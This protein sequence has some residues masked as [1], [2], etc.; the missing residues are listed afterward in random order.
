MPKTRLISPGS[1]PNHKL[2]KN[3]QLQGNYISNDGGDEG[4]AIDNNGNVNLRP[5][6]QDVFDFEFDKMK[7]KFYGDEDD[8]LELG[9]GSG[10]VSTI[11]TYADPDNN[12]AQLNIEADGNLILKGSGSQG[13]QVSAA[14]KTES[15]LTDAS[16]SITEILNLSSGAGGSDIHYGLK[17]RQTQTNLAGWDS[18]YLMHLSVDGS[19]TKVVSVDKDAKLTCP[20][21]NVANT[22]EDG[23]AALIDYDYSNAS[24]AVKQG[25]RVD[26]DRTGSVSSG[27]DTTYGQYTTVNATGA[28]GGTIQSF[29]HRIAVTGDTGGT[30]KAIGLAVLAQSADENYAIITEGGNVGIGVDDPDELLEVA[31]DTKISGS[32]KLYLYDSGGEYISGDGTDLTITSGR[33]VELA[34]SNVLTHGSIQMKEISSTP[35]ATGVD[36][37]GFLWIKNTDPTEL[38]F[39]NDDGDDIQITTS[40]LL[41]PSSAV[42]ADDITVGNAQ[43]NIATSSGDIVFKSNGNSGTDEWL[44]FNTDDTNDDGNIP[45]SEILGVNNQRLRIRGQG[46]EQDLQIFSGKNIQLVPNGATGNTSVAIW[47]DR[48]PTTG[49]KTLS[50]AWEANQSAPQGITQLASQ[51]APAAQYR[52]STSGVGVVVYY[53]TDGSGNPTFR[54]YPESGGKNYKGKITI[55]GA[56]WNHTSGS[57]ADQAIITHTSVSGL[58]VYQSIRGT[59]I[60]TGAYIGE[61]TDSTHFVI[62]VDGAVAATTATLSSQTIYARERVVFQDGGDQSTYAVLE[63]ERVGNGRIEFGNKGTNTTGSPGIMGYIDVGN[64]NA[65]SNMHLV[66]E[67]RLKL[68]SE[69]TTNNVV[70]LDSNTVFLSGSAHTAI[71][72]QDYTSVHGGDRF[73]VGNSACNKVRMRLDG[74]DNTRVF[75]ITATDIDNADAFD[76]DA[77]NWNNAGGFKTSVTKTSGDTLMESSGEIKFIPALTGTVE[78]E[79]TFTGTTNGTHSLVFIDYDATG[80]T[81]DGQTINNIALNL[82]LNSNSQTAHANG[83]VNNTGIDIDMVGGTSGTQSN[84]GIDMVLSG[85]DSNIGMLITQTAGTHLKLAK[86]ANDYATFTVADT[87]DLTI[88]T[89]GDGTTDSD[90]TLDVDGDIILDADGGN[91]TLQDNGSTYTPTAASDAATKDYVDA[92]QFHFIRFGAYISTNSNSFL[93]IAGAENQRDVTSSS[94]GSENLVFVA[95]YDGVLVKA[96]VRSEAACDS[97]VINWYRDDTPTGAEVPP[98]LAGATQAVTVDMSVDDTSYEFDFTGGTNDFDKGDIMMWAFDPT[99]IPYDTHMV[100]VLKFDTTT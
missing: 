51:T 41:S 85:A 78:F 94:G 71:T 95:P 52:G 16:I 62:H 63:I 99:N 40:G 44:R 89:V 34:A 25:L 69:S 46:A 30:S 86:D 13:V 36:T 90:L 96:I 81:G 5:Q 74:S 55:S 61:I 82:D 17:Y 64:D 26:I 80:N 70:Q 92:T 60:P 54:A 27:T 24:A 22:S 29:G 39:T 68:M 32:N 84:I 53:E 4:I 76:L 11:K 18:V 72:G 98:T 65:G 58:A 7:I 66:A 67:E 14:T 2:L 10:G 79:K 1:I 88:A 47:F 42:A 75:Q 19:A 57:T 87:G 91:I 15:G 97:S 33:N 100:I 8:Y 59:G 49:E 56:S 45:V 93:F 3:L 23:T 38:W 48:K 77:T 9:V 20:V 21:L 73:F 43:V 35:S 28:S 12:A 31:G 83:T 37:Y 50:G 6:G